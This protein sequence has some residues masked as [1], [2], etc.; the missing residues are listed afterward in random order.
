MTQVTKWLLLHDVLN[1]RTVHVVH[2]YQ[3]H[4]YIC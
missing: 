1:Y 4:T 3:E 2:V